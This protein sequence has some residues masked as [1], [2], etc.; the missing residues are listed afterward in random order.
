MDSLEELKKENELLKKELELI[1]YNSKKYEEIEK[2]KCI[3]IMSTDKIGIYKCGRTKGSVEK[4]KN[5]LQTACVDTIHILFEY[6][7]NNDS[8]LESVVHYVLDRY[9]TNSNREHFECDL[10]YMKMIIEYNG[11]MID[12][13][14]STFQTISK[15]E[16]LE[17]LYKELSLPIYKEIEYKGT[18]KNLKDHNKH[19]EFINNFIIKREDCVIIWTDLWK[20]YNNWMF[21]KYKI[22][23]K[24]KDIKTYFENE[25]FKCK[26]KYIHIEKKTYRG[27]LGYKLN[28]HEEY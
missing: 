2:T 7:T 3:Y 24:K 20:L 14:K 1:K 4:R 18:T 21:N 23:V 16:F 19:I 12:I 11:R 5:G 15:S 26:E 27:W 8:L 10:E 25:I 9:R 22:N 28:I 13:C 6:K 17:K